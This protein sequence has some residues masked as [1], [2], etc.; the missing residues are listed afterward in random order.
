MSMEETVGFLTK[1]GIKLKDVMAVHRQSSSTHVSN[2]S[3][4]ENL[5]NILSNVNLTVHLY[6]YLVRSYDPSIL[7]SLV[8]DHK[9]VA[10]SLT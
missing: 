2:I 6:D 1:A 8:F 10:K 4:V 9:K 3:E 7:P 5:R